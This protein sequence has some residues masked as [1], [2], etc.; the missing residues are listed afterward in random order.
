M[1][2]REARIDSHK[3]E[4][5][6]G[7]IEQLRPRRLTPRSSGSQSTIKKEIRRLPLCRRMYDV[8][9]CVAIQSVMREEVKLM[10]RVNVHEEVLSGFRSLYRF[11]NPKLLGRHLETV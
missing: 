3:A 2:R 1:E 9:V 8:I 7:Y 11:T 10:L 4:N 6:S 5:I